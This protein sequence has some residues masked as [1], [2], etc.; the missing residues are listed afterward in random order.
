MKVY[1][2][3][4]KFQTPYGLRVGGSEEEGN[5]L[6]PLQI[7]NY[8]LIPSSSWKGIF[9]RV[10][11]IIYGNED[12]FNEHKP[13]KDEKKKAF[14]TYY[15]DVKKCKD[16]LI[17]SNDVVRILASKIGEESDEEIIEK[18]AII[19]KEWNCPIEKLYGSKNF[20]GAI[21]ISD[22]IIN[23]GTEERAHVVIDR[24]SKRTLE[25]HLFTEQIIDVNSVEVKVIVRDMVDVWNNTLKFMAEVGT[26]IGGGKTRGIGYIKLDVKES[27]FA[28][29]NELERKPQFKSLSL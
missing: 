17:C 3:K 29:V 7:E 25:K 27:M 13:S 18:L 5:V 2:Y 28:E 23:A 19:F 15:Q 22:T 1:L 11:E 24:K 12:H 8:Y 16:E 26:F 20:A 4:L 9:R 21:T 10:T 14:E 6:Q